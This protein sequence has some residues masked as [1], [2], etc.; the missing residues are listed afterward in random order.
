MR[1]DAAS[2]VATRCRG[3][4]LRASAALPSA[5]TGSSRHVKTVPPP[6]D[7]ACEAGVE[8]LV[9]NA[10]AY[11][12]FVALV[13]RAQRDL[14]VSQLALDP[15]CVAYE[16]ADERRPWGVATVTLVEELRLAAERGVRVRL[17]LNATLL[18]D[19]VGPLRRWFAAASTAGGRCRIRGVR[20]FPQLLHAKM[21]VADKEE[22]LLLGSP[23][24]NG[25]WDGPGHPPVD[26]RRT[27]REL[28]G[29]PVHDLSV[30]LLGEP[31]RELAHAFA[32]LWN[33]AA[34]VARDDTDP[35]V[36]GLPVPHP[37]SESDRAVRIACTAPRHASPLY[38]AG[39]TEILT[40]LLAGISRARTSI[41]VEHQY[42]SSRRVISALSDALVREPALEL[43][44][45]L[46]QNP[47]VTAYRVWQNTRLRDA[48][49]LDHPRVGL[50]ALWSIAPGSARVPALLNQVFVHSKVVIID[51]VWATTG[52]ANLDGVSLHSY[53]ADF[54]SA[55]G[56]RVFRDVRNFDVNVVLD[57]HPACRGAEV[58]ARAARSLRLALWREHLGDA[59]ASR[60]SSGGGL[61][62]WRSH[63]H[64]GVASL[65]GG[66]LGAGQCVLPLPYVTSSIPRA[67]LAELGI[68]LDPRVARLCVEPSWSEVHLS[69]NWVRNMFT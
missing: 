20:R 61:A 67:Q 12:A 25:Y 28:G 36:P 42:L 21:V 5:G 55:L 66:H 23:F 43:V 9:D 29:R 39:R 27:S 65:R 3:A 60:T 11:Q 57:G 31:V 68:T 58:A 37:E 48:G 40:A 1:H 26:L 47:D 10:K 2:P 7:A 30:R 52:S 63:A 38:P 50:F 41:Y 18:I 33:H 13:R 14:W 24:A 45:V 69:P 19:T 16:V 62:E 6:P 53:G 56:E 59:V 8:W 64:A 15:D 46:N 49:L 17:L 54:A 35:L 51:D 32:E 22:A 4:R 44:V 34:D